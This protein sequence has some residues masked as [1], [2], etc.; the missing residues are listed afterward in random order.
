MSAR[1]PRG[2]VFTFGLAALAVA[3]GLVARATTP[4]RPTGL[5]PAEV[6]RCIQY[7]RLECCIRLDEAD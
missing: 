4:I 2:W 1:V 6:D 3:A 5:D 7:G